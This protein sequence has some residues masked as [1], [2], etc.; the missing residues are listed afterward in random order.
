MSA[1]TGLTAGIGPQKCLKPTGWHLCALT[2]GQLLRGETLIVMVCQRLKQCMVCKR[3][4]HPHLACVAVGAA[5]ARAPRCL[6]QQRKQ[7]FW[8]TKIARKQGAIGV[9]C[10]DQ[11]NASKV[12]AFG[13]HL[14]TD[15]HVNF[16]IVHQRKLSRQLT[17]STR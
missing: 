9:D 17:L 6:H 3:G 13:H 16:S 7:T 11:G 4:L 8:S 2:L 10:G 14:G 15:K 5:A 1:D 12:M